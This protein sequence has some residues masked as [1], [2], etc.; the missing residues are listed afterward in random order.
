M[1][2]NTVWFKTSE[3]SPSAK[4]I[5]IFINTDVEIYGR[6]PTSCGIWLL[7]RLCCCSVVYHTSVSFFFPLCLPS[8]QTRNLLR[9]TDWSYE[10]KKDTY[11]WVIV[12][13]RRWI[14]FGALFCMSK[15]ESSICILLFFTLN[16]GTRQL[17]M[18]RWEPYLLR[19]ICLTKASIIVPSISYLFPACISAAHQQPQCGEM[20]QNA[21][22]SFIWCRVTG[23]SIDPQM[24]L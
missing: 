13:Y 3:W 1:N 22:Q 24:H 17:L 19:L 4:L 10:E 6:T 2:S 21:A 5:Y 20:P 18:P 9:I 7:R 15:W 14:Q 12:G 11:K 8:S 23:N 16:W